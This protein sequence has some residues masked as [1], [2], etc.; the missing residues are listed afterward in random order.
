MS[1]RAELCVSKN[2]LLLDETFDRLPTAVCRFTDVHYVPVDADSTRMRYVMF[3][4]VSG[5]RGEAVERALAADGSVAGS[6][7][8]AVSEDERFYRLE[9]V[10]LPRDRLLYPALRAHDVAT[11]GLARDGEGLHLDVRFP[12]HDALHAF[13][14]SEVAAGRHVELIRLHEETS[15]DRTAGSTGA[16]TGGTGLSHPGWASLTDKQRAALSLAFER[17]Y[18]ET[19]SRVTLST[20]A[21]DLDV[22]PQTLSAHIRAAVRK[23]VASAVAGPSADGDPTRPGYEDASR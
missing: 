2:L 4:W 12:D 22:T 9:S 17:G 5:C 21:T 1:I 7:L 3:G 20:L 6:R 23:L 16:R 8:L 10:P 11:I 13:L 14:D 15:E 19:P 18:F